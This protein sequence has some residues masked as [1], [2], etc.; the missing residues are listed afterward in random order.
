MGT[1]VRSYL[2]VCRKHFLNHFQ[3]EILCDVRHTGTVPDVVARKVDML[4][5]EQR[6]RFDLILVFRE[7]TRA[8]LTQLV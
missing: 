3:S 4:P 1:L 7:R 6:E 2:Q 8:G 5:A